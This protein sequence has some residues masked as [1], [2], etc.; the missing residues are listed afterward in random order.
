MPR[1]TLTGVFAD[2][3]TFLHWRAKKDEAESYRKTSRDT[4]QAYILPDPEDETV[5]P[6]DVYVDEDGHRHLEFKAPVEVDGIKYSGLV[7]QRKVSTGIDLDK[8]KAFLQ[9]DEEA[10]KELDD[11]EIARR[12]TLYNRVY[13]PVTEYVWDLG[14]L[15]VLVQQELLEEYELDYLSTTDISWALNVEKSK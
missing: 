4:I 1:N 2:A 10:R 7:N 5:V 9:P 11:T 3:I 15:Y 14:E 12:W 8:V 13:K 6:K